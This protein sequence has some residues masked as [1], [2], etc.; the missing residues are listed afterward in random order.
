MLRTS[1][2][3]ALSAAS[4]VLY[5]T[6]C[7]RALTFLST[8]ASP[9]P[10]SR[11]RTNSTYL[12]AARTYATHTLHQHAYNNINANVKSVT[13]RDAPQPETRTWIQ[14]CWVMTRDGLWL[15]I[16]FSVD[17]AVREEPMVEY[18]IKGCTTELLKYFG[19]THVRDPAISSRR[20]N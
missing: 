4:H 10:I 5:S 15:N 20:S 2:T 12:T 11:P 6:P 18:C 1:I 7:L 13:I 3:P 17:V 8:P 9:V 16:R 19:E 14:G